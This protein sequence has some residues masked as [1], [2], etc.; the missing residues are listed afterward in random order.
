[1]LYTAKCF[2]PGVSED[3]LRAAVA[4]IG[5]AFHGALYLPGDEIVLCLFDEPSPAAV[6]R[7]SDEAGLPCERV[8][9]TVWVAPGPRGD[10]E[11]C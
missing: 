9:D 5:E 8:I 7:A 4:R 11:R 2:W 1:V 6:R 3:E 10:T